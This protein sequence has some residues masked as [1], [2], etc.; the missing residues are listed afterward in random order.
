MN[1]IP[2]PLRF[3]VDEHV[4]HVDP[5]G[6][7]EH[8]YDLVS[9]EELDLE[10][11]GPSDQQA[12]LLAARE[13]VGELVE[14]VSGVEGH[15][16]EGRLDLVVPLFAV[17]VGKVHAADHFEDPVCLVK[18][19][20]RAEGVLKDTLHIAVIVTQL[21]LGPSGNIRPLK[22]DAPSRQTLSTAGL[23]C[24]ASISRCRFGL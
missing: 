22:I 12:L 19:V 5:G 24:R 14:D 6:G 17:Q 7:I 13:L 23:S 20:I 15:R 9:D 18:R 4:E 1:R 3:Q 11:Q 2:R 8:A 21:P 10:Q 16:L